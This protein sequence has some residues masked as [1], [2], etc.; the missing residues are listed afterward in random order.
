MLIYNLFL[1][2]TFSAILIIRLW[3]IVHLPF[4]TN[5]ATWPVTS[6]HHIHKA[7]IVPASHE[8][9]SEMLLNE[10]RETQ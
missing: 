2:V 1:N 9:R 5:F 6:L 7:W 3:S 8:Q 4:S 10:I